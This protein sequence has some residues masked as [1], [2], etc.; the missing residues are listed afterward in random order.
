VRAKLSARVQQVN[1][2]PGRGRR[3]GNREVLAELTEREEVIDA[4]YREIGQLTR[5]EIL[6]PAST[7]VSTRAAA[8][9]VFCCCMFIWRSCE[10]RGS[11]TW[12][13]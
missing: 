8:I 12:T 4:L 1:S 7:L 5:R 6:R 2:S 13:G 3:T 11:V 9:S 10:V